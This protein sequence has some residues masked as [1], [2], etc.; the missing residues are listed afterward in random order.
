MPFDGIQLIL[1]S[2]EE[3]T[4]V[5]KAHTNCDLSLSMDNL[6]QFLVKKNN[7]SQFIHEHIYMLRS[8]VI[9]I[10]FRWATM[11]D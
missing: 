4:V 3:E 1:F 2:F 5:S 11:K 10:L 8:Y 6:S 7:F 9:Y